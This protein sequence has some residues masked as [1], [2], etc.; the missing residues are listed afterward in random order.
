MIC[1][2][3]CQSTK[4]TKEN[5]NP[6]G[7]LLV[8][9]DYDSDREYFDGPMLLISCGDVKHSFYLDSKQAKSIKK[10]KT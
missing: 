8:M 7:D 9:T 5:L 10:A 6:D 1:C 3:I 2:P 4:L